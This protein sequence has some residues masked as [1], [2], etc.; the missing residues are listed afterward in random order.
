[1]VG[2]AEGKN[3]AK[4]IFR[5]TG[6]F[7]H[8]G[9]KGASN[10]ARGISHAYTDVTNN[11]NHLLPRDTEGV[12]GRFVDGTLRRENP[13]ENVT[14]EEEE[15]LRLGHQRISDVAAYMRR[16]KWNNC[17]GE[18]MNFVA[19]NVNPLRGQ[20]AKLVGGVLQKEPSWSSA[21]AIDDFLTTKKVSVAGKP[22]YEMDFDTFIE[23]LASR[24][25]DPGRPY[26][27][28][29]VTGTAKILE[30]MSYVPGSRGFLYLADH[31]SK[32]PRY[33]NAV[34]LD[35][36]YAVNGRDGWAAPLND[37]I[38]EFPYA[39][40]IRSGPAVEWW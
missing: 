7:F 36:V 28:D 34:H 40:F 16:S 38:G 13:F 17:T 11:V 8:T 39:Y 27:F 6:D 21:L 24:R 29:N 10:A 23:G 9:A 30:Q 12:R 22:A 14:R 15:W 37:M 33:M 35:D 19:R 20:N 25:W 5:V 4:T 2:G 1:M 32:F 31:S 26:Q 18:V 3:L